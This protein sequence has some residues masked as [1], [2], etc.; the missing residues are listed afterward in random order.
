MDRDAIVE[1]NR[2]IDTFD[3]INIGMKF[4]VSSENS[5]KYDSIMN[6]MSLLLNDMRKFGVN[7]IGFI[8]E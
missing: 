8:E 4:C 6:V 7:Y 1:Y 5:L 3:L 2:I